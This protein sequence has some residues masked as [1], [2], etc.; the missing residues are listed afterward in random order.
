MIDA[1]KVALYDKTGVY[2]LYDMEVFTN[3]EPPLMLKRASTLYVLIQGAKVT[4]DRV[5]YLVYRAA[6]PDN[7]TLRLLGKSK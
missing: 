6:E 4:L 3:K 7:R 5:D 2:R 1:K